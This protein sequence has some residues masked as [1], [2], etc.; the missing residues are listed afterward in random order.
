MLP[1]LAPERRRDAL[2]R[3]EQLELRERELARQVALAFPREA[4]SPSFAT[5]DAVQSALGVNEALL[6][7]QVGIWQTYEGE[8][9]GGAWL[10]VITRD[11][12]LLHRIPDRSHFAPIVP[13]FNGLLTRED[14]VDAVAAARLH[15]DVFGQALDA[16]PPHVTRLI[17]VPDG[18]LQ[19]LAFG[20]L[21]ATPDAPPLAAR[22]ELT[23]APSATLWLHWRR[24][25]QGGL[26][27]PRALTLAD[28]DPGF[29]APSEATERQA[30]LS[31]GLR[32]G[33]LPHARAESRTLARFVTAA[34]TLI[35]AA[36]SESALKARDL[37]PYGLLHVA[38]H[39]LS[40]EAHPER[41][42]VLL[43][44][45]DPRE[46]GLLQAR[47]IQD[48][49]LAGRIVV[50]SAC[51]TASGAML[52]G[53]GVLSLARAF[54]EAGARTVIG[55]RWAIRDA[56]AAMLF[57]AFYRH[58]GDGASVSEALS[59]AK[60][61]ALAAGR[62]AS[63]WAGVELLGDGSVRP[64]PARDASTSATTFRALRAAPA[65]VGVA[66]FIVIPLLVVGGVWLVR[67]RAAGT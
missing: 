54:F 61:H 66:A 4:A 9:G 52:Q 10:T 46:D 59:R 56:D 60:R 67:R 5:L 26:V 31:E 35:G 3:L 55:T 20:A 47:E 27:A 23:F 57:D 2:A 50:L 14:G 45:G 12:R 25:A 16:L 37:T 42:A 30:V 44:P 64:F 65:L 40:D 13:V 29:G 11:R 17:V 32:L 24:N 8:F 15:R 58:L 36:A 38:A 63:V 51:Q 19:R 6:S 62:P 7:Y 22:Y 33:R 18:P 1:T 39:A 48:L 28:P 43:A 21:R 41:S 49:D 34:D 53:E